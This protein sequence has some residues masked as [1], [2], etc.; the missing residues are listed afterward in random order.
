MLMFNNV[1][2]II[3]VLQTINPVFLISIQFVL[4]VKSIEIFLFL[5][6]S[7]KYV[8]KEYKSMK[9]IS[10][11]FFMIILLFSKSMYIRKQVQCLRQQKKGSKWKNKK[12]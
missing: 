12:D 11:L 3:I 4:T 6:K 8:Y 1:Y 9:M 10:Y 2:F 5:L 7:N